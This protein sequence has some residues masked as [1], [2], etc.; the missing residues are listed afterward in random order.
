M[1][2]RIELY[3]D[4]ARI[5]KE[6]EQLTNLKSYPLSDGRNNGQRPHTHILGLM[7]DSVSSLLS[8]TYQ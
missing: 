1:S 2:F 5:D 8:L 3:A 4:A 6:M 7:F